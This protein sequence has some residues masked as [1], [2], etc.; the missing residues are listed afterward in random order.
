MSEVE[1]LT[2]KLGDCEDNIKN[3]LVE[4]PFVTVVKVVAELIQN[5]LEM[6]QPLTKPKSS[7]RVHPVSRLTILTRV[8]A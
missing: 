4:G 8:H 6:H 3:L 5:F 7:T 2:I 1:L